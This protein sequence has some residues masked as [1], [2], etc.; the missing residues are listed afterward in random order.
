MIQEC[1][2]CKDD[3]LTEADSYLVIPKPSG[4]KIICYKCYERM[5]NSKDAQIKLLREA[6]VD[7]SKTVEILTFSERHHMQTVVR[8]ALAEA[9]KIKGV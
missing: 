2:K 4:T 5:I 1:D 8:N 3:F 6:L 9:D 7:I